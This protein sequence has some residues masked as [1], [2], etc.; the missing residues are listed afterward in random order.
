MWFLYLG[1]TEDYILNILPLPANDAGV[2]TFIS[3]SQGACQI[4]PAVIVRVQ[5]LGTTTLN[6]VDVSLSINGGPAAVTNWTGA[7]GAGGIG[8][9]NLGQHTINDGDVLKVWTSNPNGVQDSVSFND[10]LQTT[11]YAAMQ[12]AYTVGGTTPD[13]ATVSD[14]AQ[15]VIS[16]GACADVF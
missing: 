1:E 8:N 7:I 14:A 12:G 6:S 16:R 15:A 3:P 13:F 2:E 5:N 9:V 11:I 10:T 4:S